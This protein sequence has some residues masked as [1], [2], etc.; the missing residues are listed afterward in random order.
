MIATKQ[1]KGLTRPAF[2]PKRLPDDVNNMTKVGK[3]L[4]TEIQNS[5]TIKMQSLYCINELV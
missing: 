5:I 3:T 4:G 1:D 2:N